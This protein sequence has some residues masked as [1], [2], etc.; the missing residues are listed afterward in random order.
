MYRPNLLM[1][2]KRKYDLYYHVSIDRVMFAIAS[3]ILEAIFTLNH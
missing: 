2:W 3:N 1:P